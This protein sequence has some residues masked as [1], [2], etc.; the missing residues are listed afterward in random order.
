V[1]PCDECGQRLLLVDISRRWWV[2]VGGVQR[3]GCQNCS[4]STRVTPGDST[5][6]PRG[7]PAAVHVCC[8]PRCSGR[9]VWHRCAGMAARVGGWADPWSCSC[10]GLGPLHYGG[11]PG[12]VC[13]HHEAG[14]APCSHSCKEC[15][16]LSSCSVWAQQASL[17]QWPQPC[18][19]TSGFFFGYVHTRRL[20]LS[21]AWHQD[22]RVPAH[23]FRPQLVHQ[24][25]HDGSRQ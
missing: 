6:R 5:G 16:V 17:A 8:S 21:G 11:V 15:A 10:R 23:R 20:L 1:V 19:A 13:W 14:P 22:Q 18:A 2:G 9:G 7:A 25:E 24:I 12:Q 3:P 4:G